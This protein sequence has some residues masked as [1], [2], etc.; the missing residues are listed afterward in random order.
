MY[1][2]ACTGRYIFFAFFTIL[3]IG[4]TDLRVGKDMKEIYV[5]RELLGGFVA[6]DKQKADEYFEKCYPAVYIETS[7]I[8]TIGIEAV[9]ITII[10][11]FPDFASKESLTD[12]ANNYIDY[13][14][15]ITG[16]TMAHVE[17]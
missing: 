1:N 3:I 7:G 6:V 8:E 2:A 9:K 4:I 17:L 15:S 12:L 16:S 14:N 10:D 13:V 5:K 11:L